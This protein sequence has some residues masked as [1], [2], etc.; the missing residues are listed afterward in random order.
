M[1]FEKSIINDRALKDGSDKH[2]RKTR[3]T[4]EATSGIHTSANRI[5]RQ[6]MERIYA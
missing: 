5:E 3:R 1:H 6:D 4:S 2:I